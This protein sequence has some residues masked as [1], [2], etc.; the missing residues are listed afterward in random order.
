MSYDSP[1][2][3]QQRPLLQKSRYLKVAAAQTLLFDDDCFY[4]YSW[5][6]NVVIAFG[7]L[8]SFPA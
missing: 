3:P 1:F 5:R 2:F 8:S 7:T 4:S 6:N